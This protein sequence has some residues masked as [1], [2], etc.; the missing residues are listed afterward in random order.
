MKRL[1]HILPLIV[2]IGCTDFPELDASM[3]TGAKDLPFPTLKPLDGLLA[4][5]ADT[6]IS[7]ATTD[8]LAARADALRRRADRLRRAAVLTRTERRRLEQAATR[9]QS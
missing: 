1:T 9:H 3:G 4:D 8:A 5:A 7:N 6:K 2:L